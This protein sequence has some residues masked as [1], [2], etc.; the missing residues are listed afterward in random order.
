MQIKYPKE[1]LMRF[2]IQDKLQTRGATYNKEELAFMVDQASKNNITLDEY[3]SHM[4]QPREDGPERT[5]T[6]K[7]IARH[8]AI[9]D[10]IIEMRNEWANPSP[11]SIAEQDEQAK[12]NRIKKIAETFSKQLN[13]DDDSES[14]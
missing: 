9:Y 1:L 6:E 2:H 14:N 10:Q 11:A 7:D 12:T 3:I 5:L 4:R 8:Q 13:G